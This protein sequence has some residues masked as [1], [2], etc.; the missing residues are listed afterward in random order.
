M[1]LRRP[2]PAH[3][4]DCDN[5]DRKTLRGDTCAW[6][7][8][9]VCRRCRLIGVVCACHNGFDG[10]YG[11]ARFC[12]WCSRRQAS[13]T[14]AS[15]CFHEKLVTS[16]LFCRKVMGERPIFAHAPLPELDDTGLVRRPMRGPNVAVSLQS[17]EGWL[18]LKYICWFATLVLG[19]SV[20]SYG[21]RQQPSDTRF[22]GHEEIV[23]D[24]VL[25]RRVRFS[26]LILLVCERM[27]R[28]LRDA[29]QKHA[30]RMRLL[31]K[32]EMPCTRV[33][34]SSRE[35]RFTF[36]GACSRGHEEIVSDIVFMW[37][38]ATLGARLRIM[39]AYSEWLRVSELHREGSPP[40]R[41]TRLRETVAHAKFVHEAHGPMEVSVCAMVGCTS[42]RSLVRERMLRQSDPLRVVRKAYR[43]RRVD[44]KD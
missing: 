8:I 33:G 24:V 41:A 34:N 36:I 2:Y 25:M 26:A 20:T 16:Q 23:S 1:V 17:K 32:S 21:G 31:T 35:L 43:E 40:A 39:M 12:A 29:R 9:T 7:T 42:L 38:T 18:R 6:C 5:C 4:P 10:L 13:A 37:R 3:W 19:C 28:R 44:D 14:L 11:E 30:S 22:K 27:L 15:W